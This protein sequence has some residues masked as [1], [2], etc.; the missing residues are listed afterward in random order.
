MKFEKHII[1]YFLS[2]IIL[3][4][5]LW[6][7]PDLVNPYY[8][9]SKHNGEI[10]LSKSNTQSSYTLENSYSTVFTLVKESSKPV[11]LILII[12]KINRLIQF[13]WFKSINLFLI[14]SN[15]NDNIKSILFPFHSYW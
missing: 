13:G 6:V 15:I 9:G 10:S 3:I 5:S 14:R 8:N 12:F 1:S 11:G 2:A 7:Y 4:T